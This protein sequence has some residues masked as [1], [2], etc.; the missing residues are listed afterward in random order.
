MSLQYYLLPRRALLVPSSPFSLFVA[1]CG[2]PPPLS[3][4]FPPRFYRRD[5]FSRPGGTRNTPI[6]CS[7]R[8]SSVLK[9]CRNFWLG[10]LSFL[11]IP[12]PTST[13]VVKYIKMN[14]ATDP[15]APHLAI[16]I[17]H[18]WVRPRLEQCRRRTDPQP[19]P[20]SQYKGVVG[21]PT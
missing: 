3:V 2:L 7:C 15:C 5:V 18:P 20:T 10:N 9:S 19:S 8:T 21:P 11:S 6:F 13:I 17:A 4:P 12:G 1:P 14:H 16:P